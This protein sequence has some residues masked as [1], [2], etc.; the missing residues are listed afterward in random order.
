M[1]VQYKICRWFFML[2]ILN[3]KKYSVS[4]PKFFV[5][6]FLVHYMFQRKTFGICDL[7]RCLCKNY[8]NCS[9]HIITFIWNCLCRKKEY[10]ANFMCKFVHITNLFTFNAYLSNCLKWSRCTSKWQRQSNFKLD[11]MFIIH[12]YAFA[13][14]LCV[15]SKSKD[16]A[17]FFALVWKKNL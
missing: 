9:R 3:D 12:I 11:E 4:K 1:C 13:L 15:L 6:N 2:L 17:F 10:D 5:E 16:N 8:A 7:E 14:P